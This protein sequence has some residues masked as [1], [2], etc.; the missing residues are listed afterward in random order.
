MVSNWPWE[1]K[2]KFL[3]TSA[4]T[5]GYVIPDNYFPLKNSGDTLSFFDVNEEQKINGELLPVMGYLQIYGWKATYCNFFAYDLSN[6]IFGH[7]PWGSPKRANDIHDYIGTSNDFYE[8]LQLKDLNVFKEAGFIV[9]LTTNKFPNPGHIATA[10]I[11]GNQI[12]QAG[13]TTGIM[14]VEQGFGSKREI[15]NIVMHVYLGHLKKRS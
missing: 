4:N 1:D 6:H 9:F 8:I 15:K 3:K 13:R 12:I 5:P 11:N 14:S 2:G 10:W 7:V